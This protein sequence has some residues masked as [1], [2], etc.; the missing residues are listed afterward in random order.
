MPLNYL[1]LNQQIQDMGKD[2]RSREE[3]LTSSLEQLTARLIE[4]SNDLIGLQKQV[5]ASAFW[6]TASSKW[7]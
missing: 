5:V 4:R 1:K 3:G 2:A 7:W 6:P